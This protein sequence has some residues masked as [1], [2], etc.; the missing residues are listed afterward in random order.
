MRAW[1]KLGVPGTLHPMILR[2]YAFLCA[3]TTFYRN[4]MQAVGVVFVTHR[5][6]EKAV[7]FQIRLAGLKDPSCSGVWKR[8]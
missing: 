7:F 6:I 5:T 8:R 2:F 4:K 3:K 1:V